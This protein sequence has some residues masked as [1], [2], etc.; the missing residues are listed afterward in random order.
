[1]TN[2]KE[3][4]IKPKTEKESSKEIPEQTT[5]TK[6]NTADSRHLRHDTDDKWKKHWW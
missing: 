5:K 6:D 3:I 2:T 4:V 1:M